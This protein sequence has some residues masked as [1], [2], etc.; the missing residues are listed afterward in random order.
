MRENLDMNFL[1]TINLKNYC[2]IFQTL[3][4]LVRQ[5][6]YQ[7]LGKMI[8][9]QQKA[10]QPLTQTYIMQKIVKGT[11][12]RGTALDCYL[13]IVSAMQVGYNTAVQ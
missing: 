9:E 7:Q 11:K 12:I 3:L 5:G 13:E 4:I 10:N 6:G 2:S 1:Q 8:I